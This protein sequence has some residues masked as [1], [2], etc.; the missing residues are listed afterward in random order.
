[1]AV[2]DLYRLMVGYHLKDVDVS[3]SFGY[4]QTEGTINA[5]TLQSAVEFFVANQLISFLDLIAD[6]VDVDF[7]RMD[8]VSVGDEIPGF[9][10]LV[11]IPGTRP[12][13]ALP[14]GGAAVINWQTD[15]PNSKH[16]GRT[17]VAGISEA[18]VSQGNIVTALS[19][20]MVAFA[21]EMREEL[22]TSLPQDAVFL[23]NIISSVEDG[24]PRV[25]KVGFLVLNGSPRQ[26]LFSQ[27]RRITTRRGTV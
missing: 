20:N 5:T 22:N 4:E 8:Q 25:P 21:L 10:N 17:Y 16:N 1:M 27:S 7:V 26:P 15:A 11:G 18:D 23:F 6:E 19:D 24:V 13:Q 3:V 9:E 14:S 12:G 2:G